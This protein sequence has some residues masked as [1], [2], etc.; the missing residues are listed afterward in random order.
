[1]FVERAGLPIYYEFSRPVKS[2]GKVIGEDWPSDIPNPHVQHAS[3]CQ[4]GEFK[5]TGYSFLFPDPHGLLVNQSNTQGVYSFHDGVNVVMCDSSVDFKSE[6]IDLEIM[7]AL[8]SARGNE[9]V[10]AK[11]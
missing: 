3:V 9:I 8:F 6:D 11:H 5:S 7:K 2:W 10:S 4:W 1:M